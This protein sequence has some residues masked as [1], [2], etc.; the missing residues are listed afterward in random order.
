MRQLL[1][2]APA[3]QRHDNGEKEQPPAVVQS[4]QPVAKAIA[5][6]SNVEISLDL[7]VTGGLDINDL[8]LKSPQEQRQEVS[9]EEEWE[10][11]D[12]GEPVS[13]SKVLYHNFGSADLQPA[14][15]MSLHGC[16]P[17]S[18]CS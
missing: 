10:N 5:A 12:T 18:S 7:S 9:S 16:T 4:R 15:N 2:D 17:C 1:F 13:E 11:V 3:M 6:G 14:F 8:L